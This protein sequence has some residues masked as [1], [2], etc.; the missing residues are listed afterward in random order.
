[1]TLPDPRF[2][3]PDGTP[4]HL[5]GRDEV[6][7][8]L[9]RELVGPDDGRRA[10]PLDTAARPT[11]E[12]ADLDQ[13]WKDQATG[14]EILTR[15]SPTRQYAVGVLYAQDSALAPARGE[16]NPEAV[17]E[18]DADTDDDAVPAL[19]RTE[20]QAMRQLAKDARVIE[21]RTGHGEERVTVDEAGED[22]ATTGAGSRGLQ[23]ALS[24][25]FLAELPPGSRLEV[26]LP[27]RHHRLD[28]P[29]NG[30][31]ERFPVNLKSQDRRTGQPRIT[32]RN[33]HVRRQASACWTLD[34]AALS[35]DLG[36]HVAAQVEGAQTGPLRLDVQALSRVNP[37]APG[38]RLITVSVINRTPVTDELSRDRAALYQTHL[39]VRV[40]NGAGEALP[41]VLPYPEPPRTDPELQSNALLYRDMPAFAAGRGI[42]AEWNGVGQQAD[43]WRASVLYGEALPFVETPSITPDVLDEHRF[44][45]AV[46]MRELAGL[47]G[48][49]AGLGTLTRVCELYSDWI[50]A[51]R[52]DVSGVPTHLQDAAERHLAQCEQALT[53]MREGL[54]FLQDPA[55]PHAATAF[56]L[57][58]EAVL[59][60][61]LRAA[62]PPREPAAL[63]A[64]RTT[65]DPAAYPAVTDR[66]AGRDL[67]QWRGFQVAFLLLS[68]PSAALG[69]HP[70]R[71]LVDLIWFPTGGGK[72]EAYLGLTAFTTFYR[73]LQE[74]GDSGVQVLMR[75]TLRLLTAQQFQRA[76]SLLC[77]ME[78]LRQREAGRGRL[79][80]GDEPFSAGIWLGMDTTPN[81]RK[82]AVRTLQLMKNTQTRTK[83]DN[84]FV[85]RACPWCGAAMGVRR[86]SPPHKGGTA[87]RVVL[88][89]S[90]AQHGRQSWVM[91]HCPDASCAFHHARGGLPVYV[92]DED[93]YIRRPSLVIAT[94]DKFAMLAFTPKARALFGLNERGER[95]CSPPGLIIQDELH[96]ISG[97]LGT[98][99]GV[100]EGVIE[101]LCTE[102]R[103]GRVPARPKI[104]CSTATIRAYADQIK[105]LY[106]RVNRHG[107]GHAALFPPPGLTAAD[108]F[109]AR[110]AT[111]QE[112]DGRYGED[113]APGRLYVG[114]PGH[115]Y[116]SL[117]AAQAKAYSALLHAPVEL[118]EAARDP[119]WTLLGFFGSLKELGGAVTMLRGYMQPYLRSLRNRR[120]L[121]PRDGRYVN[122]VRELTGRL[123]AEEVPEVIGA[124]MQRYDTAA[125]GSARAIDVALA[126]SI[127]EVGIDIPR[128]SLMCIL[129]QPKTTA[130]YIQVS[131][132][133]GRRWWERPGLVLTIYSNTRSRD[134]SHYERFRSY[135]E[136]LYA[137][138]EPTS[139]TPFSP[140]AMERALHGAL[141]AY[142]RQKGPMVEHDDAALSP[143]HFP[144]H[145]FERF[146]QMML[147]RIARVD[148]AEQ[149]RMAALLARK[150]DNW[151][152]W[153][154]QD[155]EGAGGTVAL[156]TRAGS[157][158]DDG[159][160]R[161][162][163]QTMTSMRTVDA[164][165]Q[166]EITT[167]PILDADSAS[168]EARE[169]V[170]P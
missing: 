109:F 15:A 132:R 88:G 17:A 146:S 154:Y 63:T 42:S 131:G 104:V 123:D 125:R 136:R 71:D 34:A 140:Q 38:T 160:K 144:D 90:E 55:F 81:T 59:L 117:P 85:L 25:S 170:T 19:D 28:M 39:E 97:P 127:I 23:A 53:R 133:V 1:M 122:S 91:L 79:N 150:R 35:A 164:Q 56:R 10:A 98:L 7:L 138:V 22:D 16:P 105:G 118:P 36:P 87:G 12:M 148:P 151:L 80:L 67:G 142:V 121:P 169:G 70:D 30:Y 96:L 48:T 21:G 161:R 18:E 147:G 102:D 141:V 107:E 20:E 52:L 74:P 101:T 32:T 62:L 156:L 37:D 137:F 126:S 77:A 116:S 68:L 106:A 84:P 155:Y 14:A 95:V 69:D 135:H 43:G 46:S 114:M 158:L 166:G 163:W 119:W 6:L 83:I 157:H 93:I 24:L 33:M 65:W 13:A 3:H 130:Q 110:Y 92:T 29:V 9:R 94:V 108:S 73:R 112:A 134:R 64:S 78:Y 143:E 49:D 58:N 51:R 5:K 99:S 45:F 149:P 167:L 40:V 72:T 124:L 61:Q 153:A 120:G 66:P 4:N 100:M 145:L 41:A 8:S 31:Y 60:Q 152:S 82:D 129:T 54:A 27:E 75:Y 2:F 86:T 103:P 162:T 115:G 47:D 139:V 11:L 113:P 165:C 57:A 50:A 44:P 111:L 76:T 168:A 159:Q 128:L 89:Y 26:R